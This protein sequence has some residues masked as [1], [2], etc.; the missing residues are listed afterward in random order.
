V[1]A[2]L[3]RPVRACSL[4]IAIA[5]GRHPPRPIPARK[6]HSPNTKT[7]GANPHSKVNNE[8][9]ATADI[10]ALRRPMMS[11]NAPIVRAPM[12]MPIRPNVETTDALAASSPHTSPSSRTGNTVPSTTKSNPSSRTALHARDVAQ[13]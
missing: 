7:E 8:K 2:L 4:T 9:L 5:V 3:A 6:R 10:N 11:V 13:R 1:V 12:V